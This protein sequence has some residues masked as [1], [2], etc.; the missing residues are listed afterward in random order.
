MLFD[1]KSKSQKL[2]RA[3]QLMHVSIH[4]LPFSNIDLDRREKERTW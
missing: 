3:V 1:S 2:L 4:I